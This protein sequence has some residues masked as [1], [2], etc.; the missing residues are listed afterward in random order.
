M[1]LYAER[2]G[3]RARQVA[4]DLGVVALVGLFARLGQA[5][6][7]LVERLRAPGRALEDAG[8]GLAGRLDE[9]AGQVRRL[10]VVGPALRSPFEGAADAGRGLARA[11]AEQADA[12]HALALRLGALVALLPIA[13]VLSRYLP[14]R[15]AWVREASAGAALRAAGAD[16]ELF[17]LRAVARR[18]LAELRRASADPTADLAARRF[19]RLAAL[20]LEALGLRPPPS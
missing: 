3:R 11:G 17:A 4:T 1:T 8:G 18:P 2:P 5:L 12:V 15:L 19:D 16:L 10:P 14:A 7:R 13:Y 9:V 20:E 6:Y